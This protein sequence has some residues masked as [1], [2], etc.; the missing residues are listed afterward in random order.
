VSGINFLCENNIFDI[1]IVTGYFINRDD[2]VLFL[3]D[4]VAWNFT[5]VGICTACIS[6]KGCLC[7]SLK[8]DI[9]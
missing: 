1:Y 6:V 7:A 9:S 3:R 4:C 5:N 8:F 2:F